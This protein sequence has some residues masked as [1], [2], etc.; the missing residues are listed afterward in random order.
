MCPGPGAR[1]PAGAGGHRGRRPEP[2]R[3]PPGVLTRVSASRKT[4]LLYRVRVQQCSLVSVTPSSGLRSK[5]RRMASAES[6]RFTSTTSSNTRDRTT[7]QRHAPGARRTAGHTPGDAA[8]TEGTPFGA[9]EGGARRREEAVPLGVRAVGA[10]HPAS[11][12]RTL[13][14]QAAASRRISADL[15]RPRSAEGG[16]AVFS[17]YRDDFFHSASAARSERRAES[18][19]HSL[20]SL[21]TFPLQKAM[22]VAVY[23][24]EVPSREAAFEQD[25]TAALSSIDRSA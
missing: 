17:F 15:A 9:R 20:T 12:L 7:L 21:L 16:A 25:K 19:P 3:P 22:L 23:A 4:H 8:L 13:G 5:A 6:A 2:R 14:E 1:P 10:W 24:A 18:N 11:D